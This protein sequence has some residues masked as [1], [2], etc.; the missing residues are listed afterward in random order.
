ML[1]LPNTKTHYNHMIFITFLYKTIK[2]GVLKC[3]YYRTIC[4][5][6]FYYTVKG[7]STL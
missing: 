6:C 2:G 7:R 5:Q 4:P 3:E 1:Y